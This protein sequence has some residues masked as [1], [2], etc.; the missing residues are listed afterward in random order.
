MLFIGMGADDKGV[1]AF[2]EAHSKLVSNTVGILRRDLSRLERLPYLIGDHIVALRPSCENF[3]PL[4]GKQKLCIGCFRGAL[5]GG[6]QFSRLGLV[7]IFSVVEPVPKALC[8][9]FSL[10]DVHGNNSRGCQRHPSFLYFSDSAATIV[11][12]IDNALAL[13]LSISNRLIGPP[14]FLS[15]QQI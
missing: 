9:R 5:I 2:G 8:N 14:S 12:D 10:A 1:S 6:N 15:M 13:L 7:W 4:L 3:V 11:S